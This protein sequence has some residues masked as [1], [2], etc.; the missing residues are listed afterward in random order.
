MLKFQQ[1]EIFMKKYFEVLKKCPLFADIEEE[2]L[3]AILTCLDVKV[4]QYARNET[5][6]REGEAPLFIGIVLSGSV[7]IVRGDFYG[8]RNIV[9]NVEPSE[10]FLESFVCADIEEI[11]VDVIAC[12]DS[13]IML[14]DCRK[15]TECCS[16]ACVFHRQMIYNL[17]KI[18]ATKN[19]VLSQKIEMMSKRTTREKL[20]AFLLMEQKK[21]RSRDFFI[22]YDRQE[23]ADYLGVERSGLSVEIGRLKREGVLENRK[24]YFKL[25]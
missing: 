7:Q 14:L 20:M 24:N 13:R 5:I 8:N 23:L 3:S 18:V 6:L 16:N 11:P 25:L 15:I 10:I 22:P 9:V 1:M 17:M 12:K 4:M 2:K 21:N 19:L